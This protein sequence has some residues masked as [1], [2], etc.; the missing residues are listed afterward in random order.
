MLQ[1]CGPMESVSHLG[2]LRNMEVGKRG[3]ILWAPEHAILAFQG[4]ITVTIKVNP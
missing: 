1:D 2:Y 3:L 4:F